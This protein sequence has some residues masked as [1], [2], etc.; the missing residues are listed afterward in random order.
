[1][2][3]SNEALKLQWILVSHLASNIS[4]NHLFLKSLNILL[5]LDQTELLFC[6]ASLRWPLTQILLMFHDLIPIRPELY[7]LEDLKIPKTYFPIRL[8]ILFIIACAAQLKTVF[9]EGTLQ[10]LF[11]SLHHGW[12][13]IYEHPLCP[14]GM[15]LQQPAIVS[16]TLCSTKQ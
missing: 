4:L 10:S 13:S 12:A 15:K 3:T 1:M 2:E 5:Q 6:T 8:P 11:T 7:A 16:E 14:E 9:S